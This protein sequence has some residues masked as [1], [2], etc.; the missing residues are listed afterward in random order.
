MRLIYQRG[1]H[2]S[3]SKFDYS[4]LKP[5]KSGAKGAANS[6]TNG[7][8]SGFNMNALTPI[9]EGEAEIERGFLSKLPRNIA[10]G[11][12]HAGRNLHNI[13][14]DVAVMA[15]NTIAPDI[16]NAFRSLPFSENLH[17]QNGISGQLPYD[18]NDYS[19]AL[20]QQGS[21]TLMDDLI[22]KGIE[23]APELAGIGSLLKA[24]ALSYPITRRLASRK[25]RNV[26]NMVN[27]Q[28]LLG[29]A[30]TNQSIQ[31]ARR[32][33]PRTPATSE[34][35]GNVLGGDY[36]AAF[37]MQSQIGHHARK[38]GKSPLASENLRAP[39]ARSLKQ[40]LLGQ[41]SDSLASKGYIKDAAE[42]REGIED[43][44]K[45]MRYKEN[46]LP[47]LKSIGIPTSILALFALGKKG[48]KKIVNTL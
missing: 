24:G 34:M 19:K 13:P 41:L 48:V 22:Q 36:G 4:L 23:H 35:I 10:I 25:L 37:A 39:E 21:S 43:Y 20:G 18:T 33:L 6:A 27:E 47:K 45:Y 17:M 3:N 32:F 12:A 28:K 1:G 30:P 40:N 16:S 2:V 7:A 9:E 38:L 44:A 31:E 15:E 5:M 29:F 42:L 8:E 46:I 26:E 14:H 11:L